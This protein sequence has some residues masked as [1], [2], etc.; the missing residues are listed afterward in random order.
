MASSERAAKSDCRRALERVAA[1]VDELVSGERETT[2]GEEEARRATKVA[3]E[4]AIAFLLSERGASTRQRLVDDAVDALAS[5]LEAAEDAA[6]DGAADDDGITLD[7]AIDSARST[8]VALADN[9]DLWIPVVGR[10]A[11][12]ADARAAVCDSARVARA[13]LR[14]LRLDRL[15]LGRSALD[16]AKELARKIVRELSSPTREYRA[17]GCTTS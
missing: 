12:A 1:G 7:G 15:A 11:A 10:V 8:L 14:R 4:D 2:N 16:D 13:R 5:L 17:R 9:P 3:L 6:E